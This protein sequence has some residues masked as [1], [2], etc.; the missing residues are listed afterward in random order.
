MLICVLAIA[1]LSINQIKTDIPDDDNAILFY[2]KAIATGGGQIDY[3][4][5]QIGL[6][7]GFQKRYGEK[8]SIMLDIVNNHSK[9]ILA[10][11]ALYEA[12]DAYRLVD[13][14][15]DPG[16]KVKAMKYYNQLIQDHPKHPRVVDAIFQIGMLNFVDQDYV[17]AEKQF[18]H[19]LNEYSGSKRET[20]TLNRTGRCLYRFEST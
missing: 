2:Q 12:G 19:I 4:K 16:H 13:K 11:P 20:E 1:I 9:S 5:Y 3:A 18:L 6:S 10:V 15:D 8:A 14:S 17:L 7:Y